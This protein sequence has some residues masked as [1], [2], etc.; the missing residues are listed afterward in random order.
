MNDRGKSAQQ[1]EGRVIRT[2]AKVCHVDVDGE[3]I[4]AAPRGLLFGE[5]GERSEQK[6][7]VAVGDLVRVDRSTEPASLTEVLPRKNYLG[8]Q[9]SSHRRR[10]ARIR[11]ASNP[12]SGPTNHSAKP[13]LRWR[14]PS[15]CVVAMY[16]AATVGAPTTNFTKARFSRRR[17]NA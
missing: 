4:Q 11:S 16:Q 1:Q 14:F 17:T 2:D 7:P 10:W 3:T 9:A 13:A 8:R 5:D 15:W 6:N 12:L